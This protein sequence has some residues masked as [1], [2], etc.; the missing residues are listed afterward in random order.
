MQNLTST[1]SALGDQTRFAIVEQLLNNG[2]LSVN[3][4]KTDSKISPPAF[5]RHL[6]VLRE[7]GLIKQR[8]DQQRR[9]YSVKPEAVQAI[10]AWTMDHQEFWLA[11]IDRLENALNQHEKDNP[12]E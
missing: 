9:L 7:A 11:S 8:V 6:K 10:H 2:E 5:S 1:F 12:N 3:E 4:L